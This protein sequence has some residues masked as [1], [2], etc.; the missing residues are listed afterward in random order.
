MPPLTHAVLFGLI[1]LAQVPTGLSPA[2]KLERIRPS[3][4]RTHFV[5]DKTNDRIAIWG[6][7]YD[8][9]DAGRLLEDYWRDEWAT[10]AED[11]REMK[12]LG[13]N[14]VRVHLQLA[15]FMKDAD[16]TDEEN[17]ARLARLVRLS[18]DTGLY[19]DVTGLGCYHKKDVPAWYDAL[20]ESARWEVQGRFWKA[21]AG[22][23]KESPAIFC[24]DLMNE[25]ILTGGD[26]SKDWLPGPPLG[27]KHFV[28]RITTDM[29]GRTDKEIARAWVT[30]LAAAI[31]SV[32][33]RHMIT[34]GVIPWAQVFKGAKPLF[35]AP[36]VCGPLD[37]VSVHFY[38]KAGKLDDDLA[39]LRVY[40]V[41]KP[42]VIEEI[43]PLGAS[44]E[45]TE[46]FIERSRTHVDGWI[47]FY[48][49]RTIEE[50][51]KQKDLKSALVGGW[52]RRFRALSPYAPSKK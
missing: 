15:R 12:D 16:R 13:A 52:L 36:E 26:N 51:E 5:R 9:D 39:A 37:F 47:S 32:D 31:R 35:Y 45:E 42:L 28:Q 4:D 48:W 17:L 19:L 14:V 46:T 33:D 6:F 49:G 44:F 2:S 34:V 40:E 18:E 22:V 1:A 20:E 24:Y 3:A 21:V 50:Y 23:C 43:F 38:P 10:V 30:K 11:F 8:H 25:P 29:R 41:G 27:D 7:N